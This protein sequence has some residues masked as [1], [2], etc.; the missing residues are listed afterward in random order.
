MPSLPSYWVDPTTP[1]WNPGLPTDWWELTGTEQP[2]SGGAYARDDASE[3]IIGHVP[4]AKRYQARAAMLGYA[5]TDTGAPYYL[6]RVNP[7]FHP[8]ELQLRCDSVDVQ[9]YNIVGTTGSG[10]GGIIPGAAAN[11]YINYQTPVNAALGGFQYRPNYSRAA[12]SL[13]FRPHTF[14]Y[15]TDADMLTYAVANGYTTRLPEYYRN[16]S[17]FDST[18]PVLQVIA[19]GSEPF[20]KWADNPLDANG[21]AQNSTNNLDK[22]EVPI[23]FSQAQLV[24]VWHDVPMEYIAN[25]FL[26]SK[27]MACMGTLNSNTN[28]ASGGTLDAPWLGFFPKGTLKLEAPRIKKSVQAQI[29]TNTPFYL[30]F[31]CDVFLPFSY[32]NPT[33]AAL[34]AAATPTFQG[35]NAFLWN[36]T[37]N[38]YAITRTNT[39][40]PT[41]LFAYSDFDSIFVSVLS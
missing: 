5:Y 34:V 25:P 33:M 15:L 41:G 19:A 21:P 3:T 17:I 13:K 11:G 14:P 9:G 16:C 30:P 20:M 22:G 2:G 18:D 37:A 10:S 40:T 8:D 35:W 36:R 32:Q 28:I 1:A 23:L 39:A 29:R 31:V 4:Y 6:H 7:M 27:I 24:M 38:W 26:P 12:M